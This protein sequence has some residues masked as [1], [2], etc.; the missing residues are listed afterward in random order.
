MLQDQFTP[1]AASEPVAPTR[2][3]RPAVS[4]PKRVPLRT[5]NGVAS[6]SFREREKAILNTSRGRARRPVSRGRTSTSS[7]ESLAEQPR[8][9][10]P[11]RSRQRAQDPAVKQT[12]SATED[13]LAVLR[14]LQ[15]TG[16]SSQVPRPTAAPVRQ[17]PVREDEPASRPSTT[18][19]RFSSFPAREE[20]RS[21]P[22]AQPTRSRQAASRPAPRPAFNAVPTRTLPSRLALNAVPTRTLPSSE[23]EVEPTQRPIRIRPRPPQEAAPT[24]TV[25]LN[26]FQPTVAVPS[27]APTPAVPSLIPQA[28]PFQRPGQGDVDFDALIEEFT[29]RQTPK[30]PQSPPFQVFQAQTSPGRQQFFSPVPQQAIPQP[31]VPQLAV[32]QKAVPQQAVPQ[33]AVP[34]HPG[35][36]FQ[37]V[38]QIGA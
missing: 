32:P 30:P 18:G 21:I 3:P 35:P 22:I 11:S 23:P 24:S 9:V 10:I 27:F 15:Q 5:Q 13:P 8:R 1:A 19:G 31:A 4:E 16:G 14:S 12:G 37:L 34:Q 2:L 26:R 25:P 20:P 38:T 36:S 6:S 33:Q 29:G 17:A 7:Q 28:S